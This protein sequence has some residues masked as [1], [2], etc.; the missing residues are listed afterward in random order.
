MANDD[1]VGVCAVVWFFSQQSPRAQS[2]P[3]QT[4]DDV[5]ADNDNSENEV[6]DS[7]L[8][9]TNMR[10]FYRFYQTFVHVRCV[11]LFQMTPLCQANA[12][13]EKL[14]KLLEEVTEAR[15]FQRS[16]VEKVCLFWT[17]FRCVPVLLMS[18]CAAV[19][20]PLDTLFVSVESRSHQIT[21]GPQRCQEQFNR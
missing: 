8:D 6:S 19:I 18:Q 17:H 3:V 5:A 13:T 1:V 21:I 15:D 7:L 14:A 20:F 16:E 4:V 11:L 10:D 12:E 2:Y 9:N